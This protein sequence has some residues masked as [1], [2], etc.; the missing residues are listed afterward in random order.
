MV[1][2]SP[3]VRPTRLPIWTGT[4]ARRAIRQSLLSRQVTHSIAVA[5]QYAAGIACLVVLTWIVMLLVYA[6]FARMH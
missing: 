5:M 2:S 3:S 1:T 4:R 6:P